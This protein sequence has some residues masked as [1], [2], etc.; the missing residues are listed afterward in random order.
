MILSV[1][2]KKTNVNV[3][4]NYACPLF[5]D[6]P[7]IVRVA[8]AALLA[9]STT[10]TLVGISGPFAGTVTG[11]LACCWAK[12]SCLCSSIMWLIGASPTHARSTLSM[13]ALWRKSELTT[14]VP[15]GTSG[16]L[17]R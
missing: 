10:G 13:H 16:A 5:R 3:L 12:I 2:T 11:T 9:G 4:S 1:K 17:H 7:P 15:R 8:A 14:G 6:L